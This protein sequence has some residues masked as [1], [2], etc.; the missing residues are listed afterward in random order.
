MVPWAASLSAAHGFIIQRLAGNCGTVIADSW[1]ATFVQPIRWK[2]G[3]DGCNI[4]LKLKK[5]KVLNYRQ[6][7]AL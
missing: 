5:N 4:T 1:P 7:T 3:R 2:Y 6:R